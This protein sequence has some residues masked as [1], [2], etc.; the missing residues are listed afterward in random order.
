MHADERGSDVLLVFARTPIPGQVKTRLFSHLS[1]EQ[2]CALHVAM[3]E[4]TLG[5]EF[6]GRRLI[7]FSEEVPDLAMPAGIETGRQ[8][9]GDLG[10]RLAVA[11]ENAFEE[12]ARKIVVLGS[13]TPHLPPER[14]EQAL[15]AL[16]RADLVLGPADDG[17]YY[18]IGLRRFS[19]QIFAGV[20]WGSRY[21]LGQTRCSAEG[22]G[23]EVALLEPFFD[24]DEWADLGRLKTTPGAPRTRALLT[25]WEAGPERT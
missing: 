25:A 12:G 23:F 4:D 22:A 24:L 9:Q 13:D 5:L 17:G 18:L 16:D 11:I 21:V 7:L 19:A 20:E 2:A 8:S 15:D 3:I 14:L 6:P 10:A 1:P